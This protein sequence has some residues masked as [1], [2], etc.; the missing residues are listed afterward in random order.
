MLLTQSASYTVL[1]KI[2]VEGNYATPK[3]F[4]FPSGLFLSWLFL[5]NSRD[6]RHRRNLE[7]RGRSY[8]VAKE[9]IKI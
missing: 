6:K 8:P 3:Y 2:P 7:K 1:R 4:S 5:R 9:T